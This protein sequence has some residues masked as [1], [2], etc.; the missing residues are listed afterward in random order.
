MLG[1]RRRRCA[2]IEPALIQN[3]QG[4]LFA[5]VTAQ[6]NLKGSMYLLVCN[7]QTRLALQL[8]SD[9]QIFGLKFNTYQ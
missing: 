7:K 5:G 9:L 4:G 1:Q 2:N 8:D 3:V 6:L